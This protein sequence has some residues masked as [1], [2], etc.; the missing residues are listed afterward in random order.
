MNPQE[1]SILG[2]IGNH[3][4][5]AKYPVEVIIAPWQKAAETKLNQ[6]LIA[7]F[8]LDSSAPDFEE[9]LRHAR[10]AYFAKLQLKS[11][12]KRRKS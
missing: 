8:N 7:E 6:D 1:R 12:Q 10:S 11:A 4:L 5:R 2:R 3:S 9:R